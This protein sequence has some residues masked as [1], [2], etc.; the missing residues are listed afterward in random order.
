[1]SQLLCYAR[2]SNALVD[3]PFEVISAH[4][5]R[6]TPLKGFLKLK[7]MHVK[8]PQRANNKIFSKGL[9]AYFI[10]RQLQGAR[11]W[12]EKEC[13]QEFED[14]RAELDCERDISL[15]TGGGRIRSVRRAPSVHVREQYARGLKSCE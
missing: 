5:L 15:R 14:G 9:R 12:T 3:G 7:Q 13:E 8:K 2:Q 10:V 11:R 6:R 4:V 1:M